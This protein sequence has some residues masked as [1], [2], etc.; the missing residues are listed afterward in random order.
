MFGLISGV[1]KF[2]IGKIN[3]EFGYSSEEEKQEII[4]D[5]DDYTDEKVVVDE[6]Y[7]RI[8]I[9]LGNK[10][11]TYSRAEFLKLLEIELAN[12]DKPTS[13][14]Q[15]NTLLKTVSDLQMEIMS[16]KAKGDK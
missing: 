9:E 12:K 4:K 2:Y 11:L 15:V 7:K 8:A 1:P 5:L 6:E 10:Q 16:L 14:E 13:Q 3:G